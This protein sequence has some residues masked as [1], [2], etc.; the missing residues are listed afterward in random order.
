MITATSSWTGTRGAPDYVPEGDW[1]YA[2]ALLAERC[3]LSQDIDYTPK[4]V[5]LA[6]EEAEKRF[7]DRAKDLSIRDVVE[8]FIDSL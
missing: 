2:K 1:D 6:W 3:D 4:L 5:S 7:G 8:M